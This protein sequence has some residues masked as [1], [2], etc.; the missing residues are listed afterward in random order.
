MYQWLEWH[1]GLD[2]A[3]NTAIEHDDP[4]MLDNLMSK[5]DSQDER[6][7]SSHDALIQAVM[8]GREAIVRA[9]NIVNVNAAVVPHAGSGLLHIAS[10]PGVVR[11]LLERYTGDIIVDIR[12]AEMMTPLYT[13][14]KR[15][16]S[17]VADA[18]I[19]A[20]ADVNAVCANGD[21]P[22]HVA[23]RKG[24]VASIRALVASPNINVNVR[25]HGS[26]TPLHHAAAK[27]DAECVLA[28]LSAPYCDVN[29]T[30]RK[31]YTPLH[32]AAH[33]ID[34]G[35]ALMMLLGMPGIEVNARDSWGRT[36]LH[37][38]SLVMCADG[39]RELLAAGA[40]GNMRD[41]WGR[42]PLHNAVMV[43]SIAVTH[44]LLAGPGVDPNMP[45]N[46]GATPLH[47]AA[48]LDDV[49]AA[50]A[51]AIT[52]GANMNALDNNGETPLTVAT[53]NNATGVIGVLLS[54]AH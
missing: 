10:T 26:S 41:A 47:H 20:G 40:D 16:L 9:F 6:L 11:A 53:R 28:L 36:P 54:G 13:A 21:T 44:T 49:E 12:D 22:L 38:A 37:I 42:T 25:D 15:G 29:A 32:F 34:G 30:T 2:T 14:V 1:N 48:V 7:A 52:R 5:W 19:K 45:D 23:A 51:V 31:G 8:H 27:G 17:D 4:A 43:K 39:A 18:L 24:D 35:G 33:T 3:I 46:N 50:V